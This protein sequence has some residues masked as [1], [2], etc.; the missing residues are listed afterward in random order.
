MEPKKYSG[1]TLNQILRVVRGHQ[2]LKQ[3]LPY[4]DLRDDGLWLSERESFLGDAE[5]AFFEWH[6][7]EDIDLPALPVPF[8][9]YDLAAFLL[10]GGGYFVLEPFDDDEAL[11]EDALAALGNNAGSARE[12]LQEAHRLYLMARARFG[13]DAAGV[14]QAANWLLND[15]HRELSAE[16]APGVVADV[17][18]DDRGARVKRAALIERNRRRWVSVER[19]LKDASSNGL[20]AA[21]KAD[22][23]GFWWEGD[24]LKWAELRNKLTAPAMPASLASVVYRMAG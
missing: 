10:D 4:Y 21:A 13:S 2:T 15:A 11:D 12:A 24:A 20:S 19:D 14:R 22:A 8:T 5:R 9:A 3:A 16:P 6:P 18:N 17:P 1:R 23:T 7:R